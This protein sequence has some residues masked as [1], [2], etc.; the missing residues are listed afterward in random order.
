MPAKLTTQEFIDRARAVHGDKYGYAFVV[1]QSANK[2]VFVYCQEHGMFSVRPDNHL[3]RR[4]CPICAGVKKHTN[5]SF[6]KI[7]CIV[8]G[9]T[10]GYEQVDYRHSYTKVTIVC[11]DHGPFSIS[12]NNHLK[13]GGCPGCAKT[14]FDRT[15]DGFLY[16]LRSE[17][18]RY[19]KIGITH[20]P[21]KRHAR[22]SKATPFSFKC[23]ELIEGRG[24]QIANLEKDLLSFYQQAR[25][26]EPFDGSTEWCLFDASIRERL[27]ECV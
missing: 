16:V 20:K 10:Y 18:G 22:L 3:S 26:I 5:E 23:I 15:K 4:G 21:E 13:G 14:G 25:F 17:C 11:R 7:A 1:Y 8:H 12:P 9:N 19:M 24:D 27:M 6:I 2:K